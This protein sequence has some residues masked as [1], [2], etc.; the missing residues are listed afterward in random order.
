MLCAFD[1]AVLKG[2]MVGNQQTLR[3]KADQP[4]VNMLKGALHWQAAALL[5][6]GRTPV[7]AGEG[8]SLLARGIL[9]G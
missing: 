1:Q 8:R 3:R 2:C 9:A 6:A 7:Q 4:N 5:Q